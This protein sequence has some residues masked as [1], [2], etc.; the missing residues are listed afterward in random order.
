MTASIPD[1]RLPFVIIDD[2]KHYRAKAWIADVIDQD[3]KIGFIY[4]PRIT[5]AERLA[6]SIAASL[7]LNQVWI[8]STLDLEKFNQQI[9]DSS[10]VITL[11][12][13][14]T[15]LIGA[16][17]ASPYGVPILGVNM[18]RVGFIAEIRGGNVEKKIAKYLNGNSWVEERLMLVAEVLSDRKSLLD[19]SVL[20]YALNDAVIGRG[21]VSNMIDLEAYIDGAYLTTYRA[22]ALIVATPT[23]STGYSLSAG[24]PILHPETKNI[25][26]QPV[27]SHLSL[28]SCLV[29]PESASI[30][31]ILQGDYEATLSLDGFSY[32]K[33]LP[34]DKIM[35]RKS[36]YSA[37]FLRRFPKNG[38]YSNLNMLL[39]LGPTEPRNEND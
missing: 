9:V 32:F 1:V 4:N 13:D 8:A 21:T 20:S 28:N 26:V 16:R 10:L 3:T 12:G 14:G 31:V 29:I 30:E 2:Q 27:A 11:G 37:K 5:Q 17:F 39:R 35:V 34:G 25:L 38:F 19:T 15:I 18:G 33:L 36:P 22:D 7:H 6:N 23:G 24:G